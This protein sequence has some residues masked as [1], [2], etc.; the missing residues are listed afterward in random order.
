MEAHGTVACQVAF[1]GRAP[2]SRDVETGFSPRSVAESS[3][4]LGVVPRHM[5][6]HV[7]FK[8]NSSERQVPPSHTRWGNGNWWSWCGKIL[9]HKCTG[10]LPWGTEE[11]KGRQS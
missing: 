7:A 9:G 10:E 6:W 1:L 3:Q 5:T 11:V 8:P 2:G 4:K